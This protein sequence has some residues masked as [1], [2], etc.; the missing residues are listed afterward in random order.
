MLCGSHL[1][2]GELI[3]QL[4]VYG[5]S[6]G[7][8][9]A[10]NAIGV[11]VVYGTVRT[12]NL[13]HGDVF[14]LTSVLAVTIITA[15]NVQRDW[16]PALLIGALSLTLAAAVLFGAWLNIAI[17]QTAFKPFRGRSRLAPLIA[18]LGISF[19]LFQAALIWRTY[20]PSW[21]PGDHRSVP[22][23]PEVP[24]DAIPQ[25][26]PGTNL[27]SAAGLP[28]NVTFRSND[29]MILTAAVLCV[30]GASWFLR[31]TAAGRAIRACAQD[32]QLA[33]ICGVDVD[34]AIRS[35]FAFGG[36]LAGAAAFVFVMY[37]SRAFGYHGAQSGLLAFTVAIL[38]GIG[39]PAGALISG[40]LL[41]VSAAFSDYF[42]AAQWTPVLLQALL[43]GSLVLRPTGLTAGE[44][45]EDL[46]AN[47]SRD[48]II[49]TSTGRYTRRRRVWL[50]GFIALAAL[51]PLVI[52]PYGQVLAAGIGV[53][54]LLA[55]GLNLQLGLASLLD[56][57]YAVS[58]AVGGYT[59]ALLTDKWGGLGSLL[60]Q[61]VDFI[62]VLSASVL[63]AG[64][65]G[66]LKGLLTSRL[67]SDYLAVATLALGLLV[68]QVIINLRDITGGEGG[69]S[70]LPPPSIAAHL[71]SNPTAQ[72]YLVLGLLLLVAFVSLRLIRSRIGRAWLAVSENEMAAASAGVDV[73]GSR[74]LA[75]TVSSAVA[76]LAGAV[77]ASVFAYVSPTMVSFH[78]SAMTLAMVI[79]GGA[80]SVPGVILGAIVVAGY[81]RFAI[82]ALAAFLARLQP[83]NLHF[84]YSP[85]IRGTS[86]FNFGLALYLT[87]WFRARRRS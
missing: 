34:A 82:P 7:A 28:L 22:G 24:L 16:P 52:G 58:F 62:V 38:G 63:A 5:L 76:G 25:L 14:A 73:G 86:F 35:A 77:Y 78:V 61:P 59:A 21:I 13:A 85:D 70:P 43:I 3:L 51:L 60:P 68:R 27:V 45:G 9:L 48:A 80:G 8:V 37:Y 87:V 50:W 41:G 2:C 69:L 44:R 33:Q 67:R 1:T 20:L 75:F 53:V 66:V 55:L 29:L 17:E 42:L 23:L 36:A 4:L 74:L 47:A 57:G 65:F 84:G 83:G 19:M 32:P 54:A 46:T 15:L 79:M 81:D 56:L 72:Y 10:L 39:S 11:T 26:L 40:L 49:S 31:L 30:L 64:L 12:L 71:F 18:T 6:N